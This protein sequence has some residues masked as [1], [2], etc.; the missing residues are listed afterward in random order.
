MEGK[1]YERLNNKAFIIALVIW[2]FTCIPLYILWHWHPEPNWVDE[3][4][5]FALYIVAFAWFL[6]IF[7]IKNAV[8]SWLVAQE[9][10]R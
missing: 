7:P 5:G 9:G 8:F 10:H 4:L 6:V 3:I 2:G 1:D